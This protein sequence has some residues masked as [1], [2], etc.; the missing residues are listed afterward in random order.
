MA[1]IEEETLAAVAA[2]AAAL[3]PRARR[4]A[5]KGAVYGLAGALRAGDVIAAAARGA[6]RAVQSPTAG[7]PAGTASAPAAKQRSPRSRKTPSARASSGSRARSD[8][9]RA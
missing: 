5:R 1:L 9:S 4:V 7:Q 6:A 3:S 2:T 8:A